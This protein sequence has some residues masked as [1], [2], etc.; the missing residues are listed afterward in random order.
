MLAHNA[1]MPRLRLI[2]KKLSCHSSLFILI[3]I[4]FILSFNLMHMI[5]PKFLD[6]IGKILTIKIDR[7]LGSHHPNP[8]YKYIYEQNYGFLPNTIAP[9]GGEIDAYLLGIDK[10]VNEFTGKCIAVIKRDQDDDDKLIIVPIEKENDFS[11]ELIT[12]LTNFQEK[13]FDIKIIR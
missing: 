6:T 2:S 13:A 5:K 9:D 12:K 8:K 4:P 3:F 11:D 10:P 1:T 7:P